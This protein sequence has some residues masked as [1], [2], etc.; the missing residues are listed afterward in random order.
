MLKFNPITLDDKDWITEY[1]K[2]RSSGAATYSFAIN[3][4]W[5]HAYPTEVCEKDDMLILNNYYAIEI[6][7]D[8]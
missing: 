1:Y 4:T 2:K 8:I 3:Y 6:R 7:K 5:N